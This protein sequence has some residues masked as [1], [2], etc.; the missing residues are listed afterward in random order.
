MK[1]FLFLPMIAL[2]L[3]GCK[4][5]YADATSNGETVEVDI[6]PMEVV[7]EPLQGATDSGS[8]EAGNVDVAMPDSA[9]TPTRVM[10]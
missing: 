10:R 3:A 2:L 1:K 6:Q 8:A 5:R 4:G 7:E 9:A